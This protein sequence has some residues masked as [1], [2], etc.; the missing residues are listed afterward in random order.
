MTRLS[1]RGAKRK[2][3]HRTFF[4][5]GKGDYYGSHDLEDLVAVIDG[6]QSIVEESRKATPALRDYLSDKLGALLKDPI[7]SYALAG[8]LPGDPGS[9]ARLPDLLQRRRIIASCD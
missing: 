8:H 2:V 9:Q 4:G 6:R 7:F 5:R 1:R 3:M